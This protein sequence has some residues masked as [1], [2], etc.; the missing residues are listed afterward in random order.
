MGGS[1]AAGG[2]HVTIY[3]DRL[4]PLHPQKTPCPTSQVSC[5]HPSPGASP[6]SSLPGL[7]ALCGWQDVWEREGLWMDPQPCSPRSLWSEDGLQLAH[8]GWKHVFTCAVALAGQPPVP[9]LPLV[10]GLRHHP[11]VDCHCRPLC[12]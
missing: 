7:G 11:G 1:Q 12:L 3:S 4:F 9:G 6:T 5:P 10:R 8:R 2:G